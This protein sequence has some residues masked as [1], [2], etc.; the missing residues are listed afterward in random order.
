MTE[1][2]KVFPLRDVVESVA[3]QMRKLSAS[4]RRIED[5]AGDHIRSD[6]FDRKSI[7]LSLQGIDHLV[8]T[9]DELSIFLEDIVPEIERTA[10]VDIS[11]PVR[12]MKLRELS[13]EIL[14]QIGK[15]PAPGAARTAG[16][17]DL[18]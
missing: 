5:A 6:G 14:G 8:Q 4:G 18:F 3:F 15:E 12:R 16:D 13:L 7:R 11:G 10:R 1:K 9:L 2:E 17:L